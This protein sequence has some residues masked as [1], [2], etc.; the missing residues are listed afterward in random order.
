MQ[1]KVQEHVCEE[2]EFA[3][4]AAD[5]GFSDPFDVCFRDSVQDPPREH[6]LYPCSIKNCNHTNWLKK[7]KEIEK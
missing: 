5:C 1:N 3:K 2:K 4:F 7:K 6:E